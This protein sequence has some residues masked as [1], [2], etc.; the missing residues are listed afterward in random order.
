MNSRKIMAL[1]LLI[2]GLALIFYGVDHMDSSGSKFANFFGQ[3]DS[4]GIVAVIAGVLLAVFGTVFLI[5]K[6]R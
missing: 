2:A 4:T 5:G 1:I 6:K 3:E